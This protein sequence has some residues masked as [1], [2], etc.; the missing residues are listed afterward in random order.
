MLLSGGREGNRDVPACEA[1]L[2]AEA[3][4][5][6]LP[7]SF[8][9]YDLEEELAHGGMGVVY[10]ARQRSLDR[11]VALKL[12][13]LGR[14]AGA[15]SI[16]RFLREAEAAAQLRHPNIVSIHQ[17]GVQDG[18]YYFSMEYV[19]GCTLADLV[20]PG[21]LSAERAAGYGRILAA[22]VDYAHGQGIVHRDLK[23]SNVLIDEEDQPRITDFGLAKR[24]DELG[25][26]TVTG[27]L[28]G[29][30]CYLSPEQAAGRHRE[31]GPCS[32]VYALGAI[33]YELLT[34]RPPFLGASL[35]ETLVL[36]RDRDP[37][38]PR[39]L[40]PALPADL[41]AIVLMCLAKEPRR[42]YATARE[43][44][45]DLERF[46]R[47]QPTFARPV[48]PWTRL[49][50]W[51]RRRPSLAL[52]ACL[53]LATA[54]VS[55]VFAY[56]AHR[57][58]SETA[59]L[60]SQ[61]AQNLR[62]V[63]WERAEQSIAGGRVADALAV[64]ARL[65]RDQPR[66]R[67][68]ATRL[69][70]LLSNRAFALPMGPPLAHEG[71][72]TWVELNTDATGLLTASID[73]SA[74]LWRC[75]D[76][77]LRQTIRCDRPLARASFGAGDQT[78]LTCE[79]DGE[80]RLWRLPDRTCL[81]AFPGG[82]NGGPVVA[83][84]R[85]RTRFA[86]PVEL[87]ILAIVDAQTGAELG[88]RL[89]HSDRVR[90]AEY[91]W[92]GR[93]LATGSDDGRLQIWEPGLGATPVA[94][95]QLEAAVTV[96]AFTPD[97][98]RLV[99][100]TRS[101][102]IA[103]FARTNLSRPLLEGTANAEAHLLRCS[104]DG[105]RLIAGWFGEWPQ[106]WDL[107]GQR[108][109]GTFRRIDD[110]IMLDAQWSLEGTHALLTYRSGMAALHDAKTLRPVQEPFEHQGP[111]VR[112][113]LAPD[114]SLAATASQ[115]GTARLWDLRLISKPRLGLPLP[116]RA[117]PFLR[118]CEGH[119]LMTSTKGSEAFV[120]DA[121]SG[122]TVAAP[123]THS[124]AVHTALLSPDGGRVLTAGRGVCLW[125]SLA[126]RRLA[127]PLLPHSDVT[128]AAWSPRGDW[129][130]TASRDG[131]VRRWDSSTG[132][133]LE[134]ALDLHVGIYSLEVSPDSAVLVALCADAAARVVEVA[135]WRER[136][137]PIRHLG[138]IWTV[139]FT[140]AADRILTASVDRTARAWDLA[141]GK[142][143][144]PD[145]RHEGV[146]LVARYSP[147]GRIIAS[148]GEDNTVRLWDVATG[149]PLTPPLLHPDRVWIV[150]FSADGTRLLTVADKTESRIWDVA[151]GLPLTEPTPHEGPLLRAW[152]LPESS[153]VL[154]A[155]HRGVLARWSFELAP[156]P[157]PSWL[158]ELAEA[159]AGRRLDSEGGIHPAPAEVLGRLHAI[160]LHP[161]EDYYQR[162][163]S[164]HFG[165]ARADAAT[166]LK[167]STEE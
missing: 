115:D 10:R 31:V 62:R 98:E 14:F 68:L 118:A 145:L 131:S 8:G 47:R 77:A 38:P 158:P 53:L 129:F 27:E 163:A 46:L 112:A 88:P 33:L 28:L 50:R 57:A 167:I 6:G 133:P 51:A 127:G 54:G 61:L 106:L 67:V 29:S 146:V 119:L 9:D 139:D 71:P 11:T 125:D 148:G 89:V 76:G 164:R 32:D 58:Q 161:S 94:A 135:T 73:G 1:E 137:P 82:A 93:W 35:S 30:P 43:L 65:L 40:S 104:P 136:Y 107:A 2:G 21:P 102:W 19:A 4:R 141:T 95:R 116:G 155:T 111:I 48:G 103:L 72:L 15:G 56:R 25:D 60:N 165:R 126:G 44:A 96:L 117:G 80:S 132:E 85:D 124:N 83:M 128:S 87:G 92:G 45:D 140:R 149:K 69:I 162:W 5:G 78:I 3:A 121:L 99:A 26:L 130:V 16:H 41:E 138:R 151:T 123:L 108:V 101:G 18:Q 120:I 110:A 24:L 113:D 100:G 84:T 20:R 23:P 166:G 36:I 74:R 152:F 81:A 122:Q 90:A 42:R 160:S 79:T 97:G 75:A 22:A 147:D 70:S 55:G 63:Q 143:V 157:A 134:D 142:A 13:L 34:G 153:E 66:D 7:T 64:F 91:S 86:L 37:I 114:S 17:I 49:W 159:L 154:T 39:W 144:G 109:I 105:A 59:R 12:L 52:T 150:V 156:V